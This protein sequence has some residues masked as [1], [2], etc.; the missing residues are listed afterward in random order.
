[1]VASMVKVPVNVMVK[2]SHKKELKKL[3]RKDEKRLGE[4]IRGL[5]EKHLEEVSDGI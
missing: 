4:Y 1:M 5:I 3:A 2:K